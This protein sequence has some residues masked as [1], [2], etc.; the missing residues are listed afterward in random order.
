MKAFTAEK[1]E[2]GKFE[3]Y[4]RKYFRQ[5]M[6]AAKYMGLSNPIMEMIAALGLT[7]ELSKKDRASA[8]NIT[9]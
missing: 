2:T 6:K 3:Q 5:M 9:V 1:F 7:R 8:K 4:A